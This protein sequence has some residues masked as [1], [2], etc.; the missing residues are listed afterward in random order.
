MARTGGQLARDGDD[1]AFFSPL[2]SLHRSGVWVLKG[3]C[4]VTGRFPSVQH[5][6]VT[7]ILGADG[8]GD[9]GVAVFHHG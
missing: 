6:L 4:E 5:A 9:A 2:V 8:F 7:Q 3:W 1:G